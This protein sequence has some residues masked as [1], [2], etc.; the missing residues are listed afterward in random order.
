[1]DYQF[2]Y[3]NHLKPIR[4]LLVGLLVL[5]GVLLSGIVYLFE[6]PSDLYVVNLVLLGEALLIWILYSRLIAARITVGEDSLRYVRGKKET[7]IPYEEITQLQFSF[8]PYLGGWVKIKGHKKNLRF[9]VAV[10]DIAHLSQLLKIRLDNKGMAST[11]NPKKFFSFLKTAG[12]ADDGW[13]RIERIWW[14]L[15]L[16]TVITGTTGIVISVQQ[17]LADFTVFWSVMYPTVVYV[18]TEVIFR[19]R[20][21]KLANAEEF[22]LPQQDETQ[23]RK[24]YKQALLWGGVFFILW[25]GSLVI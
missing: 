16:L 5:V 21:G 25:M 19:A 7:I 11:Y 9:T 20:I 17:E 10:K 2:R 14:K 1:M 22:S 13:A 24:V 4:N 8:I 15:L 6:A 23:E 18:I 3:R 12:F